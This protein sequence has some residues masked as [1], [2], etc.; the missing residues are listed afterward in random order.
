MLKILQI[1]QAKLDNSLTLIKDL[2]KPRFPEPK[3]PDN[4]QGAPRKWPRW[5]I[6]ALA[7]F[8]VGL[9]FSWREYTDQ[10][11]RCEPVLQAHGAV[12]APSMSSIYKQW[13]MIPRKQIENLV[14]LVGKTMSPDPKDTAVD[15]TGFLFKG[16]SVWLLLKW[17]VKKL[18]K[19]SRIFYKA[20]IIVDLKSEVVL[21]V[22]LSKSPDH[23]LK[24]GVKLIFGI[25]K[26]LLT[27]IKRIYGD[28]AYTDGD[29]ESDLQEYDVQMIVEPKSNA[30][31]H[32]NDDFHDRSVRLYKNS[33]SLWKYTHSHGQKSVIEKIMGKIKMQPIPITARLAK[34]KKKQL[35]VRFFVYNW[36][37]LLE[38]EFMSAKKLIN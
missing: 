1:D 6:V 18:K 3:Q 36:N 34:T 8:Q 25:G 21:G 27:K 12:E 24:H 32:G 26:F 14:N 11:E 37:K 16:G 19:T 4:P 35:C 31:D 7:L 23:D 30:V 22:R 15:S 17:A 5:L 9:P 33:P 13:R 29:L 10:I 28:K 20:H 2:I 38:M